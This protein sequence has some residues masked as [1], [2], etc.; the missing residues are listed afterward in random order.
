MQRSFR[1]WSEVSWIVTRLPRDGGFPARDLMCAVATNVDDDDLVVL[2]AHPDVLADVVIRHRVLAAV[3]LHERHILAHPACDA[4]HGCER[5]VWQRVEP[6][7]LLSQPL[8]R[9]AARGPMR[10]GIES[11]THVVA[12][13]AQLGEARVAGPQVGL[14][15]SKL[16]MMGTRAAGQMPVSLY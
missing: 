13:E 6:F 12:P 2:L 1:W 8:D 5:R 9:R 4:E 10:S 16:T 7:S 14:G 15:L 3:E 11:L